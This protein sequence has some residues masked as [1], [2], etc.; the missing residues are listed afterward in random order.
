MFSF[1]IL[2][3]YFRSDSPFRGAL[4]EAVLQMQESGE[5]SRMK[6]K[7]WKEKRGGGACGVS[8]VFLSNATNSAN[9]TKCFQSIVKKDNKDEGLCKALF[10]PKTFYLPMSYFSLVVPRVCRGFSFE[11][12]T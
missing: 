12:I 3:N 10:Q 11:F 1:T 6:T 7:W 8:V 5:I 4:S 2:R 9:F